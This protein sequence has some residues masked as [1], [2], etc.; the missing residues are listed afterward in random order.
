MS[1]NLT[2][3]EALRKLKE[4]NERFVHNQLTH[5]HEDMNWR[6]SLVDGQKPY[7]VI[8]ACSDSHQKLFLTRDSETS[9]LFASPETSQKTKSSALLS[10]Q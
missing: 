10:M 9:S 1:D 7:A 8:V 2:A 6:F 3:D 5:P 4:G